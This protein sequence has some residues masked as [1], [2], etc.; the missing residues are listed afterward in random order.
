MK[1]QGKFRLCIV[2]STVLILFILSHNILQEYLKTEVGG[3]LKRRVY[4][5]KVISKQGLTL[6]KGKYWKKIE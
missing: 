4:F 1:D 5:E 6:H 2:F 3:Y